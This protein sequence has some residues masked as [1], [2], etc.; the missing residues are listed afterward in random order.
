[1]RLLIVSH[2]AQATG[3]PIS[4]LQLT[5][6]FRKLG[7]ELRVILRRGGVL[8][9][10]F[11]KVATTTV[12]RASPQ[13]SFTDAA[14]ITQRYGPVMGAKCVRNPDRPYCLSK[15]EQVATDRIVASVKAWG[16]DAIYANTTHCGDVIDLLQTPAPIFTHVR[17]L[18][19]TIAALDSL[20]RRST[21]DKT[22]FFFCASQA[23]ASDLETQFHIAPERLC[24]EPP[25]V[26]IDESDIPGTPAQKNAIEARFGLDADDRLIVGAGTLTP[27]K[28]PDLFFAAA[29]SAVKKYNGPGR[30]IFVWLGEGEMHSSLL[31]RTRAEGLEGQLFFPGATPDPL[32]VFRRATALMVTSTE[33]PYP[34]VAIEG[35]AMGAQILA[36]EGGGGAVDLIRDLAAGAVIDGFD[37]PAMGARACQLAATWKAPDMAL[38]H[39]V[40][41]ARSVEKSA[42][43]ILQKINALK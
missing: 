36:F 6:E 2:A 29:A 16:P 25:A 24:V 5:R 15:T 19:P 13:F 3:A 34:R 11:E 42:A 33:D 27:R 8:A 9:P 7:V 14:N 37:A 35:A 41:A 26:A 20:R 32:P 18:A 31:E 12:W 21:L 23:V 22:R 10:Q 28:G 30:L 1:M 39:R 17:E 43:R 40:I 38:S 4:A